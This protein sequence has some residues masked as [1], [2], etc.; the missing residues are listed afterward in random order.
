MFDKQ[1]SERAAVTN[2]H[3]SHPIE[4]EKEQPL[5][6]HYFEGERGAG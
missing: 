5:V 4:E 3:P 2:E 1:K 6:P